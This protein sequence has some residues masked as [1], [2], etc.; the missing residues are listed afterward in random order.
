MGKDDKKRSEIIEDDI[1]E[2]Y[3]HD[4]EEDAEKQEDSVRG[5]FKF[6][7]DIDDHLTEEIYEFPIQRQ[8]NL[9]FCSALMLVGAVALCT[10]FYVGTNISANRERIEYAL[11]N[12]RKVDSEYLAADAE[13]RQLIED[14]RQLTDESLKLKERQG[15]I[16]DYTNTKQSLEKKL[17]ELK[18]TFQQKNDDLY[19]KRQALNALKESQK[20][21]FSVKLTPGVYVVGKNIPAGKYDVTGEGSIIAS[22]SVRESVINLKLD[23]NTKTSVELKVEHTIKLNRTTNFV[24]TENAQ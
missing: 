18:S 16:Q 17:S 2:Y 14:I 5:E 21:N 11:E 8:S 15:T 22:T 4:S 7:F 13:N 9:L 10:A 3:I 24:L 20:E 6:D 1:V 23:P 19:N 12:I